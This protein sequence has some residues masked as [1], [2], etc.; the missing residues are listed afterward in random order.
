MISVH[1]RCHNA[2]EE[3]LRRYE[4]TIELSAT[5][6]KKQQQ[7]LVIGYVTPQ[8]TTK[9]LNITYHKIQTLKN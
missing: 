4:N 9:G 8:D 1:C 7:K 3:K 2:T 5:V 6:C